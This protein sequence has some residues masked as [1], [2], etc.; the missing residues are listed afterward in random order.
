MSSRIR[1]LFALISAAVAVAALGFWLEAY[2][3]SEADLETVFVRMNWWAVPIIFVLLA[4]NIALSALRWSRIEVALGGCPPP[5]ER[6][7]VTGSLALALGTFLPGPLANV[8]C[9]GLSNRLSGASGVRGAVGG[10]LDQIADVLIVGLLA[11][12]AIVAFVT[13]S[14]GTYLIGAPVT[15]LVGWYASD[16]RAGG[17]RQRMLE[18]VSNAVPRL[19]PVSTPGLL[20]ELYGLSLLRVLNLT[21]ITLMIHFASGAATLGATL[22]SVPLVTLAISAVMLPGSFGIAEWSFSGVFAGFGI[23]SGEITLFVL[24]NRLLLTTL[25]LAFGVLA[26]LWTIRSWGRS[27][28]RSPELQL[29]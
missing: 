20:R 29:P 27:G 6:A 22:V 2:Q 21:M 14:V 12:P 9:R 1:A 19:A 8:A 10:G 4:G 18:A 13:Q 23:P 3:V 25:A 28:S 24:T 15:A 26:S 7:F 11:L 17:A 16:F 5:F